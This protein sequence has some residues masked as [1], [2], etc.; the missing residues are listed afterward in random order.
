M[1]DDCQDIV[2]EVAADA[3]FKR[4]FRIGTVNSINWARVAAQIVYYFKGYFAATS[5]DR[6][7]VCF[8]VPSGNFGNILAGHVARQMGLP[9]HKL[10]LATNENDVLDEFFK[11]GRYRVRDPEQKPGRR[12]ARRWTFPRRRISNASC[13][14][15][16]DVTPAWSARSGTR[17]SA[18]GGFD[19]AGNAAGEQ[20]ARAPG[21]FLAAARTPTAS[22]RSATSPKRF[23]LVIDPHT[24]DGVKVGLAHRESGVPLICIETAL[25]VKFAATIREALG[26]EPP[27]PA[28]YA[29]LESL[30]QRFAT[31]PVDAGAVK[32][33]IGAHAL[34]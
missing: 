27:R 4:R 20:I 16:R 25:P 12:R 33:Y 15:S 9:I 19:V 34:A 24:A 13:S 26:Q 21:S 17:S 31:L 32:A 11:S 22:P 2:K 3:E 14:T 18:A 7:Q 28:A 30:P 5:D 10:I 1:F 23:G 8:A 6:Q 29:T